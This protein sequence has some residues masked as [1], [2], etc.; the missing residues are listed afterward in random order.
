MKIEKLKVENHE[1]LGNLEIDFT[2]ESGKPVDVI[3]FIGDNGTG[4]TKV[5]KAIIDCEVQKLL[6]NKKIEDKKIVWI[7]VQL[8]MIEKENIVQEAYVKRSS[9]ELH[10]NNAKTKLV[11]DASKWKI[12][13]ISEYLTDKMNRAAQRVLNRGL[14]KE[15]YLAEI[16]SVNEIFEIL[17]LEIKFFGLS[18][19][20]KAVPVFKN[21][22]GVE[23]DINNLSSGEK[24]IFFR[25]LN[26]KRLKVND[27]IILIDEPET[28]LHPDWQ[29][30]I[31]DVYKR[32]GENNQIIIATHSPLILGS[33]ETDGVRK[34]VRDE[35][36]VIRV[37][38]VSQSY[39]KNVEHL[40][41]LVMDLDD[42]RNVDIADKIDKASDAIKTGNDLRYSELITELT[43]QLSSTDKNVIRLEL[44][45]AV[46]EKRDAEHK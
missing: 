37:E 10:F 24:Q 45:K 34:L 15:T 30:K 29:R 14:D 41:K 9:S 19:D 26:L 4:K 1:V 7:P 20:E 3:A 46:K 2:D 8:P 6:E 16:D 22:Q 21:K 31:I 43:E 12:A 27:T 35:E 40:L 28:S 5:L 11:E 42:V 44:E 38:R 23:V 13:D 18:D 17:D 36:G 39:G 33:V 25:M 32:I